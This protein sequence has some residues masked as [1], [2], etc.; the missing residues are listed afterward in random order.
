MIGWQKCHRKKGVVDVMEFLVFANIRDLL[1]SLA[2]TRYLA[3]LSDGSRSRSSFGNGKRVCRR[4]KSSGRGIGTGA[5]FGEFV[6]PSC[7]QCWPPEGR[8]GG[9]TSG[10][11]ALKGRPSPEV[12]S[13]DPGCR[14]WNRPPWPN[15]PAPPHT[16]DWLG[17]GSALRACGEKEGEIRPAPVDK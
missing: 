17:S 7:H 6:Y 4:P 13:R 9:G 15:P 8:W 16:R 1:S 14:R 2:V 5:P 11:L 3:T 12:S 10:R